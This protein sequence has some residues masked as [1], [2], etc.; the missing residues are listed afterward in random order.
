[1]SVFWLA[2]LLAD[3]WLG[4][5]IAAFGL[6]GLESVFLTIAVSIAIFVAPSLGVV[7]FLAKSSPIADQELQDNPPGALVTSAT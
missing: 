4:A 2:Y 7:W 1:M 5:R 3:Y 6:S